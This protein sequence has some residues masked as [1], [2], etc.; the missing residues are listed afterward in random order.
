M[1]PA[2]WAG[3]PE[4]GQR[5]RTIWAG[6]ALA[7]AC[8]RHTQDPSLQ[9]TCEGHVSGRRGCVIPW[10]KPSWVRIPPPAPR[11]SKA[12]SLKDSM[13]LAAVQRKYLT[14]YLILTGGLLSWALW[15]ILFPSRGSSGAEWWILAESVMAWILIMFVLEVYRRKG[16]RT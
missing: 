12:L 1:A 10:R 5:I 13:E 15:L 7:L 9:E 8:A 3:V 11:F 4:S 14:S 16:V 2:Y 6:R